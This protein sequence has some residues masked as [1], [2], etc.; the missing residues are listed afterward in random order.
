MEREREWEEGEG[1]GE[2][3]R[4]IAFSLIAKLREII[5]VAIAEVT[6]VQ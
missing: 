1:E 5:S 6:V 3:E 2:G 4:S